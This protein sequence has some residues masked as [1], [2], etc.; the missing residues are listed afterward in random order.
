[1]EIEIQSLTT[2]EVAQDGSGISLGFVD[3]RGRSATIRSVGVLVDRAGHRPAPDHGDVAHRRRLFRLLFDAARAAKPTRRGPGGNTG[4]GSGARELNFHPESG[5]VI[6][7][8][9]LSLSAAPG[10]RRQGRRPQLWHRHTWSI[11]LRRDQARPHPGRHSQ[12]ARRR[13]DRV[14]AMAGVHRCSKGLMK[15]PSGRRASNRSRCALRIDKGRDRRSSL[16]N[17]GRSKA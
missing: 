16:S 6:P 17:A 7:G 5:T 2:C 4:A 1:M 3:S 11:A 15:M 14:P 8:H 12:P 13:R 10:F 9:P